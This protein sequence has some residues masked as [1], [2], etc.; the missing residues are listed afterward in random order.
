MR[1]AKKQWR[2]ECH[3][4]G[5]Y[6]RLALIMQDECDAPL[7]EFQAAVEYLL[8]AIRHCRPQITVGA[9]EARAAREPLHKVID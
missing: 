7:E 9:T 4:V 2:K 8:D 6:R 1:K 5:A 3:I